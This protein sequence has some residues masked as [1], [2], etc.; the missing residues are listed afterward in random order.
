M[1]IAENRNENIVILSLVGRLDSN[2]SD[3]LE[4]RILSR[5]DEGERKFIIDC[6]YLDYISSSGLRVLLL[7]AKKLN[8]IGGHILLSSLQAQIKQVFECA[9]FTS[10][11]KMFNSKEEAINYLNNPH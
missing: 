10:L 6:S 9:G 3:D 1:E 2:T 5:I 8:N 11:F 7:G 4:S